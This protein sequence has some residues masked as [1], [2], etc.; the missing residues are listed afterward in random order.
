MNKIFI[1]LTIFSLISACKPSKTPAT[2]NKNTT[3]TPVDNKTE[4]GAG[5]SITL[6]SLSDNNR[7]SLA[8]LVQYVGKKPNQIGERISKIMGNA[9][10]NFQRDWNTETPIE[11]DAEMLYT[12]GC[13]TGNCINSRYVV[14]F[15]TKINAINVYSFSNTGQRMRTFEEDKIFL[16]LPYKGQDWLDAIVEEHMSAK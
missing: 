1:L 10:G 8:D 2:D 13:K 11:K 9:Y 7:G 16:A 5:D 4:F 14:V 3:A 15:D 6:K 12:S